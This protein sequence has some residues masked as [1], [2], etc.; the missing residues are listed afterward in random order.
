MRQVNE[1]RTNGEKGEPGESK[2]SRA[3]KAAKAEKSVAEEMNKEFEEALKNPGRG[4]KR[5]KGDDSD[6]DDDDWEAEEA[7][8]EAYREERVKLLPKEE[9]AL[10]ETLGEC[11]VVQDGSA[12][13]TMNGVFLRFC[14]QMVHYPPQL[15]ES[16][17]EGHVQK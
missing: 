5:K 16:P 6:S 14:V 17:H 12:G 4:T 15:R 1:K 9:N 2:V 8:K 13:V 7:A 11:R 3:T 10:A